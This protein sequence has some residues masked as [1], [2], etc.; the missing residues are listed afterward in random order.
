VGRGISVPMR[1]IRPLTALRGIFA[2]W[3]MVLHIFSFGLANP[4]APWIVREGY[5]AV[6]FFFFLSGY[7]LAGTYGN[8][9][10]AGHSA[11]GYL[12]YVLRR[13]G[14]LFPLHWA[15]L[16][17]IV[18]LHAVYAP[19][20]IVEEATLTQR[21]CI[22]P[23]GD[24]DWVNLPSWSISTEWAASLLFPAFVWAGLQGSRRRA[25]I[26]AVVCVA[27]LVWAAYEHEWNLN[28]WRSSV[29]YLPL[30]RCF[31]D[32]G[33]G[34][35]GY[36]ARFAAKPLASDPAVA[37]LIA[38]VVLTLALRASDVVIVAVILPTVV[39]I[40]ANTGRAAKLL[41]TEPLHW[42]GTI[43]YSIYLTH[44]PIVHFLRRFWTDVSTDGSALAY[45]L[46]T[47][48]VTIA[49]ASVTYRVIEVP[50]RDLLKGWA[51][52]LQAHPAFGP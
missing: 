12:D 51:G 1:E 14:R 16:A 25:S 8:R 30:V 27:G 34:V 19:M 50:C 24:D 45:A 28:I 46:A 13:F 29:T 48:A 2:C 31:A 49:T 23:A 32:F 43:S 20:R 10:A 35:V 26:T 44:Y 4:N 40:A 42:L 9:M 15:V 33:L 39:A 11:R 38:G 41:S 3:V 6:D 17:G 21:W 18:L 7:I 5:L 36:R 22:W 47:A 52:R 37:G